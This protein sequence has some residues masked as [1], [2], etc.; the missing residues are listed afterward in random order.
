[1]LE[2]HCL[3]TETGPEQAEHFC[4]DDGHIVH[5]SRSVA[6]FSVEFWVEAAD[7]GWNEV[8]L[9]SA[10]LHG[11][12]PWLC[13]DLAVHA[14][15]AILDGLIDLAVGLDRRYRERARECSA[16]SRPLVTRSLPAPTDL[17]PDNNVGMSGERCEEPK[18]VKAKEG[19]ISLLSDDEG[20][21]EEVEVVKVTQEMMA[22][23]SP[24]GQAGKRTTVGASL[25][26]FIQT[27][28][29]D[30]MDLFDPKDVVA[31]CSHSPYCLYLFVGVAL[32]SGQ[33]TSVVLI[34]Y[35]DRKTNT[36]VVKPLLTLQLGVEKAEVAGSLLIEELLTVGLP[37][38]N[39]VVLYCNAPLYYFSRVL[40]SKLES[41]NPNLISL[42]GLT[43]MAGR[44][45]RAALYASF[46]AVVEL[47]RDIHVYYSTCSAV[48]DTLKGLFV[49]VEPYNPHRL[50]CSQV[51]FFIPIVQ[52]MVVRWR[53]LIDYFKSLTTPSESAERIRNSLTDPKMK[54]H[55]C[56]L[57]DALEPLRAFQEQQQYGGADVF[58]ELQVTSVLL[59]TY[60][61]SILHPP[62]A[63][64]FL[65]R[66]NIHAIDDEMAL[67]PLEEVMVGA[68]AQ[69]FL[70]ATPTADLEER[71]RRHFLKGARAF[72]RAA[73]RSLTES[74]PEPLGDVSLKNIGTVLKH[75]ESFMDVS[76]QV[77]SEMGRQLGLCNPEP[78]ET[79]QLIKDYTCFVELVKTEQQRMSGD[80]TWAKMLV[81]T[82]PFSS[83]HRLVL[84]L[85]ALPTSLHR[86]QVFAKMSNSIKPVSRRLPHPRTNGYRRRSPAHSRGARKGSSS[87]EVNANGHLGTMEESGQ[88]DNSD[89]VDVTQDRRKNGAKSQSGPELSDVFIVSS[90]EEDY[91]KE[92]S[93]IH[94]RS[95]AAAQDKIIGELVWGLR[96]GF[97]PWPAIVVPCT[98]NESPGRRMV[99]WYAQGMS[100]LVALHNLKPF[101]E[102]SL[103]FSAN[104]LAIL[105]TYPEA[106]FLSLQEA[107]RRCNK[108][109]SPDIDREEQLK[110]MLEWALGGFQPTGPDGLKPD[111]SCIKKKKRL[112]KTA[113]ASLTTAVSLELSNQDVEMKEVSDS[114]T[115]LSCNGTDEIVGDQESD[116]L[117]ESGKKW[118]REAKRGG[119]RGGKRP[120]K[121]SEGTA[122]MS[123]ESA[124]KHVKSIVKKYNQ[125][126]K[127]SGEYLLPNQKLREKRIHT[128]MERNLDLDDY[129]L[130]CG[131]DRTEIPHPLFKGGLCLKCMDNFTETL[132]RYDSDNYQSYCTIC[133][134]GD[135]VILCG[136]DNCFRAY[137]NNCL[138]ILIGPGTFQEQEKVD[139]WICYLCKPPQPHFALVPRPDWN[140]RLAAYFANDTSDYE[141]HRIYPSIPAKER[142]PVRVLS[143]FDGIAT[144]FFVLSQ[145]GFKIE[146]YVA[147]E[148]S[149]DAIAVATIKHKGKI[150]HIGDVRNITPERLREL[151][152]FDL[153]IGGSP[154]NDLSI[155]NHSRKGIYEGSGRLFFDYHRILQKLKPRDDDLRPFFWLFENTMSMN[156]E[157]KICLSRFLECNPV[158]MNAHAVSPA[159]RPR[160]F[161]GNIPGMRRPLVPTHYDKVDLQDCLEYGR[162]ARESKV[163]VITTN[164]N[165][166]KGKDKREPPVLYNGEEDKIW[167]TEMET[168]FGFPKHYTDVGDMNRQR[169][170]TLLGKAWSVPVAR[171]LLAPL[172]EY[173]ACEEVVSAAKTCSSCQPGTIAADVQMKE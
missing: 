44:A 60:A 101:M 148:I 79:S 23:K 133:C 47:V 139:P 164:T 83:L 24:G 98:G 134:Y 4:V 126:N 81:M 87:E 145:L 171:H 59:H 115:K 69:E 12:N 42:C 166:L 14:V 64:Y 57:S 3:Q 124:R 90:D 5:G 106:V 131:D 97:P 102:F 30:R 93:A 34:G 113:K 136:F 94:T 162:I 114:L 71:D 21:E 22:V 32:R 66:R 67:L 116:N 7:S 108:H 36:S 18:E 127:P 143:L 43:G 123:P 159:S 31:A 129:C 118:V 65:R 149:E 157:H 58:V 140:E 13:N 172:K 92:S 84:T 46:E 8:A 85:L 82:R 76:M 169:R 154:C 33:T 155:V 25:S 137:C 173:F 37:L 74:I 54:L 144:G 45:C 161:W 17:E 146:K 16:S 61:T 6:D 100:S 150:T 130:C 72:Y 168:V 27:Y 117:E 41:F 95:A 86:T 91:S 112:T 156:L 50:I 55:F 121:K 104:S 165:S 2:R 88:S 147:S 141:P 9:C 26:T 53:D 158:L 15:P 109:F 122:D 132:P 40:A 170:H 80:Y 99:R 160:Y 56:F 138:D 62:A 75:P 78:P 63:E 70:W 73:L 103:Y 151:G 135:T 77:L 153:L 142:K 110:Q 10:F 28:C 19:V 111:G 39:I 119:P 29:C 11:L 105:N 125:I 107:A 96:E 48:D 49:N 68:A 51:L 35:F 52:R 128:V 163:M 167:I 20:E 120:K 1:M 89:V 38:S 152:P